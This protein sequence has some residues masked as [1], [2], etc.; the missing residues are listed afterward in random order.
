MTKSVWRCNLKSFFFSTVSSF[1]QLK[2]KKQL[3]QKTEFHP[4]LDLLEKRPFRLTKHK[5]L[6]LGYWF[7]LNPSFSLTLVFCKLEILRFF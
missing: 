1:W 6:T 4:L 2:Y 7:E 5:P 3:Q